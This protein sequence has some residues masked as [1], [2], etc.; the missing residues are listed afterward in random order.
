MTKKQRMTTAPSR[1]TGD[2]Q[3]KNTGSNTKEMTVH[4]D[5]T[6]MNILTAAS[7]TATQDVYMYIPSHMLRSLLSAC[8]WLHFTH[9]NTRQVPYLKTKSRGDKSNHPTIADQLAKC[10][11]SV[12]HSQF[13]STKVGLNYNFVEPACC[14]QIVYK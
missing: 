10:E 5:A 11:K 14:Y 7:S 6:S 8:V 2:R 13:R 12:N 3:Q 9:T 1:D 4:A